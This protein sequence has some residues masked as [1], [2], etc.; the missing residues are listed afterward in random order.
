MIQAFQTFKAYLK[1]NSVKINITPSHSN[2][3]P[4]RSKELD[5]MAKEIASMS[6]DPK[7]K[8]AMKKAKDMDEEELRNT[9]GLDED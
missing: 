2:A 6:N 8:L 9:F 1:R 3:K 4:L 5:Q 7:W